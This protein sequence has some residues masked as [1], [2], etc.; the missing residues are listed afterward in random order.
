MSVEERSA[1]IHGWNRLLVELAQSP[2]LEAGDLPAMLSQITE[3]AARAIDVARASVWLYDDERTA[4]RC[5]DLFQRGEGVHSSGVVLGAKDFPGYFR[6]LEEDRSIPANDAHTD[7]RTA[8]FSTPYLRPLGIDAMLDV[9]IRRAGRMI[10]VLCHEHIGGARP[11][12]LDEELF[13]GSIGDFVT[14]ALEAHERA[15]A[16]AAHEA[17]AA[18]AARL[19][20]ELDIAR[21]LQTSLVPRPPIAAPGLQIAAAMVTATEVGGDYYDVVPAGEG[22]WIGIGDVSGHGLPAGVVML[23]VQASVAALVRAVPHARPSTLVAR[24]AEVIFDSVHVRLA[25]PEHVTLTLL[26]WDAARRTLV[27]AGAH[28]DLLVFRADKGVV[29][30][31]ETHGTWLGISPDVTHETRDSELALGPGDILLLHTDGLTET[32]NAAGEWFELDRLEAAFGA[33]AREGASVE[34]IRDRILAT[35]A[36]FGPADDDRTLVVLRAK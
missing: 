26:H 3:V 29:E 13:A 17:A 24:L 16:E 5:L 2:A 28:E 27:H 36:A 7:P 31:H 34:D 33:A 25:Q 1:R 4:I 15:R 18:E 6:A 19:A 8:E 23:M 21:R 20:S 22:A 30:R 32:R 11:W 14:M 9:P 10:G 12:T 35:V